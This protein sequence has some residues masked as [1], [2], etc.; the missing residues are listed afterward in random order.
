MTLGST[1]RHRP[2][3]PIDV[4]LLGAFALRKLGQRVP[5]R[6]G[7]KTQTLIGN[8]ALR[9]GP[10]VGREEL[11]TLLWPTS[12]LG[13][14]GQALNTLVYSVHRALGDALDGRQPIFRD[15]DRYRLDEGVVVDVVEFDAAVDRAD[16]LVRAG[17]PSAAIKS[18]ER[19]A[20]LYR[21]DLV[22]SSDIA[23]LI[24]RERLRG[25]YLRVRAVLAEDQFARGA[26]AG[27]LADALRILAC[28]PCREDAHRM[29]MRTYVRLGERAQAL[30]QYRL[31]RDILARE[32]DAPPESATDELF[33]LI[34]LRPTSV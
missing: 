15:H 22:F 31:C 30:R 3:A 6:A 24:E 34:R 17:E 26:F 9:R 20:S 19:A 23:H 28:D 14:A 1:E 21:G 4:R 32:F 29:A 25:R 11:I 10:G 18:Y 33:D 2:L 5:V 8:L 27:A 7:G 12:S 13:L 16:W